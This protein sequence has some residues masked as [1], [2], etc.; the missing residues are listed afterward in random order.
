MRER[1]R[2][3]HRTASMPYRR[4]PSVMP[5]MVAREGAMR[6]GHAIAK[7]GLVHG[8]VIITWHV[9]EAM[10]SLRH[11]SGIIDWKTLSRGARKTVPRHGRVI[12]ISLCERANENAPGMAS[13]GVRVPRRSGDRSPRGGDQSGGLSPQNRC[14][15]Q[16]YASVIDTRK[17][18]GEQALAW[19]GRRFIVV[20]FKRKNGVARRRRR[21]HYARERCIASFFNRS[22]RL[23]IEVGR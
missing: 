6:C 21:G 15:L 20:V 11:A 3:A 8:L 22:S 4:N 14:I 16:P 9:E 13:E 17:G 2:R 5:C 23:F 19:A 18:R 12:S 7:S 10:K 1:Q